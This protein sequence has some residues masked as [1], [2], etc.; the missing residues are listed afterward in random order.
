MIRLIVNLNFVNTAL[1]LVLAC[2]FTVE[3]AGFGAIA[4]VLHIAPPPASVAADVNKQPT[5]GRIRR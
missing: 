2:F 4:A 1:V 3:T 5:A